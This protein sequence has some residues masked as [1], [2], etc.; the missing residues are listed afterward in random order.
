MSSLKLIQ[1]LKWISSFSFFYINRILE[2]DLNKFVDFLLNVQ[3]EMSFAIELKDL[4]H[5]RKG[6]CLMKLCSSW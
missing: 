1:G 3:S 6:C 2:K 5:C 4:L